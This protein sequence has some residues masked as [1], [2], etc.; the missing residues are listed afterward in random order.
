MNTGIQYWPVNPIFN[1]RRVLFVDQ[2]Q[3]PFT[4]P[5]LAK[6]A[7]QSGDTIVV[8]PG[9][10][11]ANDLLKPGVNWFFLPGAVVSWTEPGTGTGYGIFDDRSSGACTCSIGGHGVFNLTCTTIAFQAGNANFRGILTVTNVAS[12]INFSANR[13]GLSTF[14]GDG[15]HGAFA[16]YVTNCALVTANILEGI[17]G[18]TVGTTVLDPGD[19][20]TVLHDTSGGIYWELGRLQVTVP[21]IYTDTSY[22]I[23]A[24]EPAGAHTADASIIAERIESIGQNA[25]AIYVSAQSANYRLWV[26]AMIISATGGSAAVI[27]NLDA[28]GNG[29]GQEKLY[30]TAQKIYGTTGCGLDGQNWI[31]TEKM[32]AGSS[33]FVQCTSGLCFLNV[34]QYEDGGVGFGIVNNGSDLSISGGI[35]KILNGIGLQHAGGS[36][37]AMGLLVNTINTNNAANHA[38]K[39]AGAGCILDRCTLVAPALANS[40]N[41]AAAQTVKCYA[42]KA[43]IAKHANVTVQVDALTVDA[44]VS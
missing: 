10:Y 39:L 32:G 29:T 17:I 19:G 13:L 4:I 33:K 14:N 42:V 44:N 40:I 7:A 28:T 21:Q 16:I 30:V 9:N 11:I 41:S 38:V 5:Q 31:T 43:N 34:Q 6:S 24:N 36:T 3:G 37:R 23:W 2:T 12:S 20:V 15:P 25:T 22:P 18:P 8:G 35:M 27:N 1:S 26:T